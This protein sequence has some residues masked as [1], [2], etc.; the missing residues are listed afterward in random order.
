M[1]LGE[2]IR[3]AR[4]EAGMS[5][6]QLC[7]EEITRNMLSLIENGNAKPSMDTLRYLAGRLGKPVSF[8]LEE[9]AVVLPNRDSMIQARKAYQQGNYEEARLL[10]ENFR[11]PDPIFQWEY[12]FL[13]CAT[14][15]AAAEGALEKGKAIYAR[16][17]LTDGAELWA[18]FPDMERRRLLLM[19]RI[20]GANLTQICKSLPSI[21]EEL[22]LR[23]MA[24]M[25]KDPARAG[26]FLDAAENR[27]SARWQY[28]R[29]RAFLGQGDY[30]SA[31]ECF[32][33][34]EREFPRETA[35]MLETCY[36][37]LGDFKSAYEYA[38]KQR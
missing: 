4:L 6:R 21:D 25:K 1:E 5:Q 12:A 29:G 37:E 32:R 17:L 20:K 14:T 35:P 13:R 15:L 28:Y 7:A 31:A 19:A 9:E 26:Q 30:A 33:N 16:E 22:L 38:L 18:D 3:Q 10:L 34:A 11:G 8:F 23:A 27:D 2:K 24:V 36:K